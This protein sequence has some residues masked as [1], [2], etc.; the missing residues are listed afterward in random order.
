MVEYL[1]SYELLQVSL[2]FGIGIKI[3]K[4]PSNAS[5]IIFIGRFFHLI[6]LGQI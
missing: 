3:E 4:C 2:I 5:P 1:K 6:E